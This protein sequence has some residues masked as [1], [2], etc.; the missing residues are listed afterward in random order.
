MS[1]GES[2]VECLHCNYYQWAA[3]CKHLIEL[4]TR[5]KTDTLTHQLTDSRTRL[6]IS[7]GTRATGDE[8]SNGLS[9][10]V[11]VGASLSQ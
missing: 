7:T 5:N 2:L 8:Q 1:R 9:L 3:V 6:N 10:L 4:S 11:A